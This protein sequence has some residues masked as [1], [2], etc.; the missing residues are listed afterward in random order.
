MNIK[1]ELISNFFL[2]L[3][4]KMIDLDEIKILALFFVIKYC[5]L[6]QINQNEIFS[7]T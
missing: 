3:K 4:I 2:A 6:Y 5:Q 7:S 1:K